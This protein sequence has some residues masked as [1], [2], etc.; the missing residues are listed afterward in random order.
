MDKIFYNWD[1]V[2]R[3]IDFLAYLLRNESINLIT[4]LPRGGLIPA[5]MLSHKMNIKYININK[6]KRKQFNTIAL[7]DDIC[8]SGNTIK[9]YNEMGFI[10][11]CIDKKHSSVVSPNYFSYIAPDDKYIVYPWENP[12]SKPIAD[13]LKND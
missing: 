2:S 6:T 7:V 3:A 5:V 13:Y 4:G 1:D 11:I 12:E 8:D 9:G 10:T